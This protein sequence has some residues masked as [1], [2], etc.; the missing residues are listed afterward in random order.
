MA[1][2]KQLP[3]Q[4]GDADVGV[5]VLSGDA[6]YFHAEQFVKYAAP[7]FSSAG[8]RAATSIGEMIASAT[9][10]ALSVEIYMKALLLQRGCAVP[11]THELPDLFSNLPT[12]VQQQVES[13]YERLRAAE[14][15]GTA[16]FVVHISRSPGAP[17]SFARGTQAPNLSLRSVL[18]RSSS[19]FVTWR[20]L[21]AHPLTESGAPLV[22]EF[23]RLGFAAQAIR[24][25]L[26][27]VA[28]S[29]RT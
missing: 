22:Y 27:T 1:K 20:Y 17:P 4:P 5:A 29:A 11:K 7:Q 25:Q 10:L 16:E 12:P 3:I 14:G 13:A 6:F 19:A 21:F 26:G 28:L 8:Q 15:P 18:R 9:S 2:K 23:L 24:E